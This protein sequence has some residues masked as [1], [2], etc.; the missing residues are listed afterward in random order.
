M[1][2][3]AYT[4]L[5]CFALLCWNMVS[6][7]FFYLL[8]KHLFLFVYGC[9]ARML[10]VHPEEARRNTRRKCQIPGNGS[11]RQVSPTKRVLGTKPT[12]S[13]TAASAICDLNP[14][15]VSPV[16]SFV[17]GN[18]VTKQA[19]LTLNLLLSQLCIPRLGPLAGTTTPSSSLL[20]ASP[21]SIQYLMRQPRTVW[22]PTL[23]YS[24]YSNS[25]NTINR[26]QANR[27]PPCFPHY[28]EVCCFHL[29]S[30]K[31]P[32]SPCSLKSPTYY[33]L[34]CLLFLLEYL[35]HMHMAFPSLKH[36]L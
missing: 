28:H 3:K 35:F 22:G 15:A 18:R 1:L 27:C 31:P 10:S 25:T 19:R 16:L 2:I 8:K 17:F 4:H 21:G 29:T 30:N 12:S 7:I 33:Q 34:L 32:V 5:F 9:F 11:S 36:N 6:Q 20:M 24:Q 26:Q 14:W 13:P 23:W